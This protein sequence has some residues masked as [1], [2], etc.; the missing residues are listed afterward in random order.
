MDVTNFLNFCV[1]R[2]A[3]VNDNDMLL[4]G[5]IVSECYTQIVSVSPI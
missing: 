4:H 5:E 1:D 2:S 3:G